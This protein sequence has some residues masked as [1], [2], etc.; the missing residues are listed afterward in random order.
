MSLI[1]DI[2]ED[3]I[4]ET[5]AIIYLLVTRGGMTQNQVVKALGINQRNVSRSFDKVKAAVEKST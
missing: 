1:T 4:T 3:S 2:T 5:E